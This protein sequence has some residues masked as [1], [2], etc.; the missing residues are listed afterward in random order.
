MIII[1]TLAKSV[2][3]LEAQ[4]AAVKGLAEEKF[5]LLRLRRIGGLQFWNVE[6]LV[7]L[8]QQRM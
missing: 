1:R 5:L 6:W 3:S 2:E 7:R 8:C 4:V